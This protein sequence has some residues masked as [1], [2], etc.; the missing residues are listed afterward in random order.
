VEGAERRQRPS[1]LGAQSFHPDDVRIAGRSGRALFAGR[2]K[3]KGAAELK[4]QNKKIPT[5]DWHID[6]TGG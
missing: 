2:I 1:A 6:A 5:D 3:M 4:M